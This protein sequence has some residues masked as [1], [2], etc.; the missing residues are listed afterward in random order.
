MFA[1]TQRNK[2][3]A[4]LYFSRVFATLALNRLRLECKRWIRLIKKTRFK[5]NA[6]AK[7]ELKMYGVALFCSVYWYQSNFEYTKKKLNS[8][9]SR[10]KNPGSKISKYAH[11]LNIVKYPIRIS[12]HRHSVT[13]F[14]E[15]KR[16][17][18]I[19]ILIRIYWIHYT[20]CTHWHSRFL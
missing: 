8:Q 7:T 3:N 19:L 17:F 11:D 1:D 12:V 20:C 18:L 14:K 5:E 2:F 15:L 10:L 4:R 13:L 9:K 16:Y 6:Y